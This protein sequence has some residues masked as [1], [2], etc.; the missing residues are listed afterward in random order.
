MKTVN[1]RMNHKKVVRK[2]TPNGRC[3]NIVD[4]KGWNHYTKG[5]RKHT[6]HSNVLSRGSIKLFGFLA[7][8]NLSKEDLVELESK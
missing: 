3:Y 4:G 1:Q 7:R 8:V 2:H 6:V 5:F